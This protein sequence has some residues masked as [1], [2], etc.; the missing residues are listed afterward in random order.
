MTRNTTY[1]VKTG[2]KG[3]STAR[4]Q[5]RMAQE[6]KSCSQCTKTMTRRSYKCNNGGYY[7]LETQSRFANRVTCSKECY[8]KYFSGKNNKNYKG[9]MHKKCETCGKQGLSYRQS[10]NKRGTPRQCK[11]C[12]NKY[13]KERLYENKV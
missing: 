13:R 3:T 5:I 7:I 12:Y 2:H 9:L 4:C 10:T 1:K 11:Q 8:K 6:S